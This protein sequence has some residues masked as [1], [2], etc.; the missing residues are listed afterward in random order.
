MHNS[1]ICANSD[2]SPHPSDRFWSVFWTFVHNTQLL[3]QLAR[4]HIGRITGPQPGR[5]KKADFLSC[6]ELAEQRQ[7]IAQIIPLWLH[8]MPVKRFWR[9]KGINIQPIPQIVHTSLII[10]AVHFLSRCNGEKGSRCRP[11]SFDFYYFARMSPHTFF[12]FI[13]SPYTAIIWNR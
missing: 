12:V 5:T 3:C 8:R 4:D 2:F 1:W 7:T 13:Y 9:R 11:L 6:S 10:N